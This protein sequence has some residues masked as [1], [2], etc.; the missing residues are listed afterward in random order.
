[1]LGRMEKEAQIA[2]HGRFDYYYHKM[3]VSCFTSDGDIQHNFF[4]SKFRQ[5][6]ANEK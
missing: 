3:C 6:A 5:W 4:L 1:M 2:H